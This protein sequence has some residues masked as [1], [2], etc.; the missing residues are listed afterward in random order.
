MALN[1]LLA[2]LVSITAGADS[3]S[4]F[5]S[6]L[7][8]AIGGVIVVFSIIFLDK[9]KVDDPVGAISVHGTCGIWGTI[10]VGIFGGASLSSQI[11]GVLGVYIF[12]FVFSYIVFLLI[13][14]TMGVRVSAEEES[15]GL[16][17]SEHGQEA[18]NIS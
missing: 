6:V 12:A 7:M 11:I 16:D 8:G 14:L 1:G 10:A 3:V 18:Y 17:I 9:I 13:K 4:P 2:G 15:S 5:A